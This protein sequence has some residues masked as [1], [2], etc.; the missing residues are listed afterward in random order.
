MPFFDTSDETRLFYADAGGP[1]RRTFV[2]VHAWALSSGMWDYQV[3][4]FLGAGLRCVVFDR[5]G[6]GR[7]DLPGTGYDLDRLADDLADLLAHLE[8]RDVVLVGHSM[9]A[10]EVIRYLSRHGGGRVAGIV[11]SAPTTPFL[12]RTDDNPDGPIDAAAFLSVQEVL[13]RDVGAVVAGT[14]LA[15]YFGPGYDVSA[16]LG[17]WT[18]RQLLDTPVQ[19]LLSTR[20]VFVHADQREELSQT[21]VP[22]LVIQGGA[23][24]STPVEVT[25][26]RTHALLP[27]ARLAVLDGAGHGVYMSDPGRYNAEILDFAGTLAEPARSH[28]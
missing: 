17:D 11:L 2:F 10:A 18:R 22:A 16:G 14:A 8:L 4:D 6:H 20:A 28:S 25:G 3:P 23:D 24:R 19:V 1:G 21:A 27:G 13:R 5:R 26:R 9:G 12:L 7:S 15:D